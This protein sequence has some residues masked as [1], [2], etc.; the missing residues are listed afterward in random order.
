MPRNVLEGLTASGATTVVMREQL[1]RNLDSLHG[2]CQQAFQ[3]ELN[4]DMGKLRSDANKLQFYDTRGAAGALTIADVVAGI[5]LGDWG[6]QTLGLQGRAGAESGAAAETLSYFR[7]RDGMLVVT[8]NVLL[9]ANFWSANSS[10]AFQV[11][12]HELLHFSSQLGDDGL[13]AALGIG[14]RPGETSSAALSRWLANN[15]QN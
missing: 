7:N 4:I 11:L 9:N 8:H 1:H 3:N 10:D 12:T 2:N 13:V 15:C 14:A 6:E 5:N